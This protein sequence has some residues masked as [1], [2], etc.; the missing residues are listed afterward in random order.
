MNMNKNKSFTEKLF[1]PINIVLLVLLA[2]LTFYPF[3]YIAIYSLSDPTKALSGVY[4]LPRGF[5]LQNYITILSRNNI[6]HAALISVL[7]SIIV[8]TLT[9]IC[10]SLFAFGVTKELLPLRK[11]MYR[12]LVISMYVSSGLIPWYVTMKALHLKNNFLLYV[13]PNIVVAF[14]IILIKTYF[15]QLPK[16]L[17]ESAMI[18]GASYFTIFWKIIMPISKPIL[19]TVAIFQA[20]NQWNAWTDN[21]YLCTSPKLQTLQLLLLNFLREQ[22]SVAYAMDSNAMKQAV[23]LTPTSI[24]MTVTVIVILPIFLLYPFMQKYFLKGIMLG[25]VKG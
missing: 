6:A 25:A 17:E 11:F 8:T 12:G 13:L 21:L 23:K 1:E 10:S 22:S 9:V 18:D 24:R 4:L 5:T 3:Y 20:V 7:R 2:I 19:A 15:E 14:F 16:E